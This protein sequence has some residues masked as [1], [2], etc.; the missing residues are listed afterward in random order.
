MSEFLEALPCL[1]IICSWTLAV[2]FSVAYGKS[3]YDKR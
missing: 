1:L 2:A 3:P